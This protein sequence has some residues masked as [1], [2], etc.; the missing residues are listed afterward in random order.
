[1]AIGLSPYRP[2]RSRG[3]KRVTLPP[4]DGETR[5]KRIAIGLGGY[6]TSRLPKPAKP[7]W[8]TAARCGTA[9]TRASAIRLPCAKRASPRPTSRRL[10]KRLRGR[11]PNPPASGAR[12]WPP[13]PTRCLAS[14]AWTPLRPRMCWRY[15]N[16]FGL[17]SGKPPAGFANGLARSC[18]GPKPRATARMTRPAT[19]CCWYSARSA[20]LPSTTAPSTTRLPATRCGRCGRATHGLPQRCCS[21]SWC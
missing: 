10:R 1:M 21:S 7:P 9:K 19:K 5:G 6:P 14:S 18:D 17:P 13:T 2:A 4:Q 11:T 8:P 20:P 12:R 15:P 3:C 16:R